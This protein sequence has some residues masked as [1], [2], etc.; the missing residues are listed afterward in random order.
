MTK[1]EKCAAEADKVARHW[2][3]VEQEWSTPKGDLQAVMTCRAAR[4]KAEAAEEVAA[5]IRRIEE[6]A[7]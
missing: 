1:I 3:S 2:R 4:H 5:A 6:I 7:A